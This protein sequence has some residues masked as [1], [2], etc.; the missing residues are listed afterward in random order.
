MARV[1]VVGSGAWGTALAAHAS[2]LEHNVRLWAREP[3]VVADVNERHENALF[4]SGIDLPP[5]LRASNDLEEVVLG[6]DMVVL[7]PPSQFLRA[8]SSEVAPYVGEDAIVVVACKGI[9]EEQL[10][11]MSQVLADT[12]QDIGSERL[13]FLSGP[14]F[15]REVASGLPTDVVAASKGM[16]AARRLQPWLHSPTFRVYTSGDPI[17]VEVGG[18]LKNVIAVAAGASDGLGLG[19]NARAALITRGLAEMTRL[20]VALGADPLTF[21][22]MAGVGDLVLTCTGDLSRNRTLGM[23]VAAGFDPEAYLASQRTVAEGFST[24]AAAWALAQKVGVDMPIT[25]QV[26][27]V[28]HRRR[29]LLEALRILLTREYKEELVGIR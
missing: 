10:E 22:G 7:V 4:L 13:V 27:H 23:K 16:H 12:M 11:L 5:D 8:V 26:Y 14:T 24:S 2:R 29:P 15:A 20:G 28:L 3:Q 1:A 9:E 21:L 6:A 18:A 25:E 17:G 19:S